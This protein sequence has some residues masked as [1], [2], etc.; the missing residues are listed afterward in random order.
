MKQ[1][2][3]LPYGWS[4]TNLGDIC[5]SVDKIEP[6]NY[7]DKEFI[8][9]E[10]S[11]IDPKKQV[12]SNFKKIIGV[13][14]PSRARQLIKNGDI[15]FSTVRTYLKNIA[16]VNINFNNIVASTGFC[17]IRPNNLINNKLLFYFI[18]SENFLTPLNKLQ[19][20]TSYPA[21]RNSDVYNQL[22][23]IP[24][25]MEQNRIVYKIEE[26]FTQLDVGVEALNTVN[27]QVT[28]YRQSVLKS[29]FDGT[30]TKEWRDKR[31]NI[32]SSLEIL[33]KLSNNNSKESASVRRDVPEKIDDVDINNKYKFPETWNFLSIA[34]LLRK[35]A[36]LDVKD[37]N[38]GANHPK[39]DDFCNEGLPFITAANVSNYKIDYEM[40][41]KLKYSSLKKIKVGFARNRDVVFTH[42]GSVGRV[43]V[44]TKDC[45]LSPQTTYYRP[46]E[47]II[48]TNF[49]AYT[50]SS[51]LFKE[52]YDNVKSQT[53]R[54]FV[55]ISKQ[56]RFFIPLPPL[57][58]QYKIVEEIDTRFSIA[59]EV[60][61]IVS[62]NIQYAERI[63]LSILKRAYEGKLVPQNPNEQPA[64]ELLQMIKEEKIKDEEKK[65]EP[66]KRSIKLTEMVSMEEKKYTDKKIL[67]LYEILLDKSKALQPEEL[68]KLSEIGDVEEFYTQLK[69]QVESGRIIENRL[70]DSD[71]FLEAAK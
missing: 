36:L 47:A 10:I 38:H 28:K 3:S 60:E 9:I 37:G 8:Y 43:G 1:D 39:S 53:T 69:E 54:D 5:Y 66:K 62:Q 42:K 31:R 25:Q 41:P 64:E 56:Y 35:G 50:L 48:A 27:M 58:E 13:D 2:F 67:S 34:E 12:L 26:L 16:L 51:N 14:A 70:N 65:R 59:E 68:F 11:S 15:L 4:L 32:T 71:I 18:Q 33:D 20:G 7:P 57:E 19:R 46:N 29:A 17:I 63:K 61:K 55:S 30:L 45:I 22:I 6:W 49:L 52:Q 40:A 23:P 44:C 24:P 21:V